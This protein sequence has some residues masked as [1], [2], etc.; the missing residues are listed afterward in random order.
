MEE[1]RCFQ[2]MSID[3]REVQ[4]EGISKRYRRIP[5]DIRFPNKNEAVFDGI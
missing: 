2:R 1:G 4:S 3:M 5:I